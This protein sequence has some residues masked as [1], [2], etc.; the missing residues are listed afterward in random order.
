[1]SYLQEPGV[2]RQE[3]PLTNLHAGDDTHA[4]L[5]PA[6]VKQ[7]LV[8]QEVRGRGEHHSVAVEMEGLDSGAPWTP[9]KECDI[10][11]AVVLSQGVDSAEDGVTVGR[12][13]K[14]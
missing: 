13:T 5:R 10:T 3:Q 14:L 8:A 6:L 9:E 11:E 2:A 4:Q 12:E 1:M 7:E